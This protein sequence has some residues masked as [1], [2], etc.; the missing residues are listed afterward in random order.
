MYVAPY[1]GSMKRNN[2]IYHF[3]CCLSVYL[4]C[5]D[6][7][8]FIIILFQNILASALFAGVVADKHPKVNLILV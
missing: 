7:L 1:S 3:V 6:S 4:L 5:T 2:V 8:F